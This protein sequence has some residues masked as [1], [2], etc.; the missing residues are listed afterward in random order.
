MI[1]PD[2][3]SGD[4]SFQSDIMPPSSVIEEMTD[5]YLVY[6]G[7]AVFLVISFGAMYISTYFDD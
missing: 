4:F 3:S 2:Q 5:E 7:A 6:I 1:S